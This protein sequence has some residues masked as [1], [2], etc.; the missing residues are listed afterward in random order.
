MILIL[1]LNILIV[2]NNNSLVFDSYLIAQI[3][4]YLLTFTGW[5][6][7][8]KEI[9]IKSFFVPFYFCLMNYTV[10]M[11]IGRFL[12]NGQSAVWEKAARKLQ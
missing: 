4:F 8:R 6:F 7:E 9:K 5:L 1:L 12:T 11:G 3:I 10:I 2:I